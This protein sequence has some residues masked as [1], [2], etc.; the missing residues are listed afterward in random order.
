MGT[1]AFAVREATEADLPAVLAVQ[2]RAFGR[3]AAQFDV[4]SASLP[5]LRESTDDLRL[6]FVGGTRFFVAVSAEGQVVGG[7]RGT[8]TDGVVDVGRLVVD[9]GWL[10]RG[11]AMALMDALEAGYPTAETFSLFTANKA[12]EPLALYAKRGY[13]PVREECQGPF[14]LVWLEKPG[15][16]VAE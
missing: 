13:V 8:M 9:D 14:T 4:D 16:T 2:R 5:P 7:V 11:V 10:R 3:V 1:P 15:L 12:L 6:L